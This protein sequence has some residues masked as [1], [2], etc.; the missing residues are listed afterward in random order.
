MIVK[1]YINNRGELMEIEIWNKLWYVINGNAFDTPHNK[2]NSGN[3]DI[4]ISTDLCYTYT[5]ITP[6]RLI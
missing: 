4:Y 3:E 2:L 1:G 5:N 6:L